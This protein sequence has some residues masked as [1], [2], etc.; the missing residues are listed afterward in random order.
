M[1]YP[2]INVPQTRMSQE[3]QQRQEKRAQVKAE[4]VAD[5]GDGAAPDAVAQRDTR[6]DA[7]GGGKAKK[8]LGCNTCGLT[9][10]D[11]VRQNVTTCP[12]AVSWPA[13]FIFLL[14]SFPGRGN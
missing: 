4:R 14:A 7:G 5:G 8:P 1:K 11:T 3:A 6:E 13:A 9:F 10:P 2:Y 12:L